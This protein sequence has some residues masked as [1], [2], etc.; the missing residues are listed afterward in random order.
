[1]HDPGEA[2]LE[3]GLLVAKVGQG[4]YVYTG[5]ELLPAAP[6]RGARGVP[7]V[8]EP[9]RRY[10]D[11]ED[12]QGRRGRRGK[13]R[14][15]ACPT[16]SSPSSPFSPS[17]RAP[18]AAPRWSSIP[19]TAATSSPC[20][21]MPSSGPHPDIDVRWLDM[22]SQE[23]LDRLRFERVNPQADVWFGGPTT[24][25]DRGVQRLAARAVP[26]RA[27]PTASVRAASGPGDLL[28]PGLPHP[29]G[30]RLQ[31]PRRARRRRAA[32]LGRRARAA[33]V[34]QGADPRSHGE[35]HDARHLGPHHRAE[36][37]HDRRHDAAAWPGSAGSTDRPRRTRSIPPSWTRGWRAPRGW[38]RCGTCRT[39]SS[40]GPRACR[41]ATS[42]RGAAPW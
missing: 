2:P 18:T 11:G 14:G 19:R 30:D 29:G 7:A 26:S 22:G 8:R 38:S 6:G 27:G 4:T 28:L 40:A 3:G 34:R 24:I 5:L 41:S 9:A 39:S 13:A 37:P 35:R 1:M 25:F 10:E 32:G 15:R 42:F 16:P 23:I 17:S 31:Q 33:L 12:G 21:S 20:S 36:P